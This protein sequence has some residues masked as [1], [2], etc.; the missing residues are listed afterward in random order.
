LVPGAPLPV[1]A[2][3]SRREK[4]RFVSTTPAGMSL[5]TSTVTNASALSA[6]SLLP[7]T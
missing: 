6:G 7:T 4:P 2:S 1:R 3:A 5:T